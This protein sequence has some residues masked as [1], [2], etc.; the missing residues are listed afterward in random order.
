MLTAD[1]EKKIKLDLLCQLQ[2]LLEE[3][4]ISSL[5]PKKDEEEIEVMVP[6][7]DKEMDMDEEDEDEDDIRLKKLLGK[8]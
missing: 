4:S 8:E 7:A 6:E 2:D 1:D 5:A 3:H